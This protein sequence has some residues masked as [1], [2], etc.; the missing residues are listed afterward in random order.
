MAER[1]RPEDRAADSRKNIMRA[2]SNKA[3]LSGAIPQNRQRRGLPQGP[4]AQRPPQKGI[5]A[6]QRS[7][8]P[9]GNQKPRQQQ[10]DN[11]I[12]SAIDD[13]IGSAEDTAEDIGTN[14]EGTVG[15]DHSTPGGVGGSFYGNTESGYDDIDQEIAESIFGEDEELEQLRQK[16]KQRQQ[17]NQRQIDA[18]RERLPLASAQPIQS[19]E[20]DYQ[21]LQ[22]PEEE[23]P[24]GAIRVENDDGTF[25]IIYL[26]DTPDEDFHPGRDDYSNNV[27]EE[28]DDDDD[29]FADTSDSSSWKEEDD[30]FT[31]VNPEEDD[32][33]DDEDPFAD[34]EKDMSEYNFNIPF[35]DDDDDYQAF[36]SNEDDEIRPGQSVFRGYDIN[37]ILAVAFEEG[38]SD[39]YITPYRGIFFTHLGSTSRRH[40]FATKADPAP[41][42]RT[43]KEMQQYITSAE[44]GQE[45]VKEKQIDTSYVVQLEKDTLPKYRTLVEKYKGRRLRVSIGNTNEHVYMVFRTITDRVPTPEALGIEGDMLKWAAL[46]RGLILINGSTGS[47][48][49]TTLSSLIRQEQLKKGKVFITVEKPVEF[50]Y[51]DDGK[52]LVIQKEVG[53]DTKSFATGLDAAMREAPDV[54]LIGEVRNKTEAS[55]LLAAVDTGHL[56]LSTMHTKNAASTLSRIKKMFSIEEQ[57]GVLL[58][59]AD[60]LQGMANQ[61]LLKTV[62]GESRFAVREILL[63]DEEVRRLIS[64]GDID[65]VRDYQKARRITM[66]HELARVAASGR[67]TVEA[68][69]SNAE[70]RH[71]FDQYFVEELTAGSESGSAPVYEETETESHYERLLS[72]QRG[73]GHHKV[74]RGSAAPPEAPAQRTGRSLP[75]KL[76]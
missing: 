67:C 8:N 75:P 10:Y 4:S 12:E 53:K 70:R 37:S 17:Q 56:A 27:G 9:Q 16:R 72:A 31:E 61:I 20:A 25:D 30:P 68:A 66:E 21:S 28:D 74:S 1:R 26:D 57:E 36:M 62:D 43:T 6:D 18:A 76:P 2:R 34:T 64:E 32:D 39:V 69:I 5:A 50:M 19:E 29:P 23:I 22:Q 7:G 59:F 73:S 49:S 63:I 58:S 71:E 65:G 51:P 47:G 24:D 45:F 15:S 11:P 13:V 41:D 60:A 35:D 40:D 55:A 33:D 42:G 3:G 44:I 14:T 48:K 38:V 46:P 54:I 52:G